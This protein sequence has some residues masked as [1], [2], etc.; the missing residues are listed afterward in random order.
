VYRVE[1]DDGNVCKLTANIIAKSMY[2][3]CDA[4]G[5][6][7]ILFN[8]FVD[9]K[10]NRKA[11]TKDSQRIV[12]NGRN[13]LRQ[14]TVGWHLCVQWKDGST[15]WQ[16]LKDLKEAYPIA[17]AEYAVTQG[18]DNDPAFNWWV[19]A[20]LRKCKHI[21]ALVQKRSTCFLKKTHKF[22]IEVP[23]S[24]A[25]AYALDKKNGNTLWADS[26][27]KEIKK[28][29]VAFKILANGDKVPIGF[30]RM[31]CHMIFD[32]KMEDLR[33][34]S[35]LVAGG[36]M[37]DAPATTTF[38]SVV[39]CKTVRIALTLA[40]LN[41]L[42]VKVSDIENA[43]IATLCTEKIWTVLGPEF[44]SDAGKSAIV[45]RALYGLKSA[46]ASFC[47]HL[48]DC[49]THLGFTPC[50]ADPDLWMQVEVHPSDGVEYYAY[51]LLYVDDVL[52]VHHD[53]TDV[54]LRLDKYFKM[55][56]RL[57][58]DPDVYLGA[59][60][61][62]MRL[63]NGIVAWASSP[64]K[65]VQALVDA[66]TKYLTNLGD[67]RWSMP[68]KA[69]NPF[70][71]YH[72]PELDTTPKLSPELALWYASLIRMLQWMVEIGQ[73]DIITEVSKMAS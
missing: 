1:F 45:V 21:I 10:S 47:N 5:N 40:G 23:R 33:R 43:Y 3:S 11:M 26:I 70:P 15:S 16:S 54:L 73:V 58:G 34:K 24:V 41:D 9:Y 31:L 52:V 72:K 61:M 49:M 44:G 38:A 55:K 18:I 4:D 25:E 68:K 71:G 51:V 64:S 28:V 22:G 20:V 2:A 46:G 66:V 63:V 6:E 17:V 53:A 27:A 35:W 48:A 29:R 69:S 13:S 37:T 50:L 57:I 7:Y 30:Q 14:S 59:T 36:H 67:N 39:S 42:Q 12:H 65:Y 62:Q 8:S 60:I 56:P 19:H 32:I